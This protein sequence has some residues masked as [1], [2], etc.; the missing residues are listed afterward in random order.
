MSSTL[1]REQ[2][3]LSAPPRRLEPQADQARRPCKVP[4]ATIRRGGIGRLGLDGVKQPLNRPE[5]VEAQGFGALG[6]LR[7]RLWCPDRPDVRQSKPKPHRQ[8]PCVER[9]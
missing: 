5:T 7:H 2:W 8:P 9:S 4:E 6:D 1:S 3:S